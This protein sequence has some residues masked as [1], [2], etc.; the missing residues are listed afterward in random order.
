MAKTPEKVYELMDQVWEA[1]LP[2]AKAEVIELQKMIDA[3][4]KNFKFEAW[5][6][7]YYAEKLKKEKY[8]LDDEQLK[9]YFELKN[10]KEGMFAVANKLWGLTFEIRNDLPVPHEDATVYE[11]FDT[12]G[13]HQAILYMDFHPRESKQGGAWMSSYRKQSK[14]N[15]KNITP[16][17][18]MVM[19][20]SK[21][22][23]DKP[24]LLTFDEVQNHVS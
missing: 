1:A 13:T 21:P 10:V 9:P 5:D 15:G 23:S 17:I 2:M 16:V 3:E 7:W 11:V 4:S 6:W 14:V 19:N 22:T 24:S 20:F 18:T 8:D 12:D